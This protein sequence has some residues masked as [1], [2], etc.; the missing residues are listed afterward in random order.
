MV[1]GHVPRQQDA[2][3]TTFLCDEICRLRD[4]QMATLLMCGGHRGPEH[5]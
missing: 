2:A 3:V 5:T 4:R 1:L